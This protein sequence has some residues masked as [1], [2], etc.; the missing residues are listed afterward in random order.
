MIRRFALLLATLALLMPSAFAADQPPL[1]VAVVPYLTPGV[2]LKLFEPVRSHLAQEMQR[3]IELYTAPDIRTHVKRILLPDFDAVITAA[4]MGRLAQLE[5]GYLPVAGFESPLKGIISV[6][7]ESDIHSIADLKNR[8]LAINDR[9]VLVSIVTLQDMSSRGVGLNDIK[10]VSAV[11]QNSSLLSVAQGDVDAA[12]TAN[13]TLNQIPEEQRQGM[14]I[15]HTTSTLPNVLFLANP[16]LPAAVRERM[17][18]ALVGFGKTTAGN[19]FYKT[20]GYN[21]I[22]PLSDAYM[23][24]IDL[25]IPETRRILANEP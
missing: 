17:Q 9:L 8:S 25:Y 12:I 15:I 19:Q 18:Q 14:R 5:A 24:T 4:H 1:R 22:V 13:F 20:S 23:K 2:L 6:R 7:K 21:G 11:T 16:K 10:V 3:P